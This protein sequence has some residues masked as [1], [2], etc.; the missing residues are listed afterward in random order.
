MRGIAILVAICFLA[1]GASAR[2]GEEPRDPII[3]IETGT[4]QGFVNRIVP[5]DGTKLLTI[6]DDQ[7]ARVW[8]MDGAAAGIIRGH[9][10][11]RDEGALYAA[12]I[13]PRYIAL[14]G[15]AAMPG[16][17]VFVRLLDRATLKPAGVLS[18]LPGSVTA[19]AFSADGKLLA[20]GFNGGGVRIYVLGQGAPVAQIDTRNAAVSDLSF[21]ADGSLAVSSDRVELF[22]ADARLRV[23]ATLPQG[24][25]PWRLSRSPDGQRLA[26]GSRTSAQGAILGGNGELLGV[27]VADGLGSAPAVA[28]YGGKIAIG[29][30]RADGGFLAICDQTGARM[31][32]VT[33]GEVPVTALAASARAVAF[34]DADGGWGTWPV[35]GQPVLRAR[36]DKLSFRRMRSAP[37]KVSPDG[38]RVTLSNQGADV[39]ELDLGTRQVGPVRTMPDTPGVKGSPGQDGVAGL[40][41]GERV[42]TQVA[43]SGSSDHMLGTN[44]YLRRTTRAGLT[45]WKTSSTS[46]IWGVAIAGEAGFAVAARG[47]GTLAWH[48]LADGRQAL[49]AIVF[50][51]KAWAAW[52]PEGFYD[53]GGKGAERIGYYVPRN[54][55]D[56]G[57][58]VAF[59]RTSDRFFRLDLTRAALRRGDAGNT[60]LAKARARIGVAATL[61]TANPP[62]EVRI[63]SVCGVEVNTSRA[64]ACYSAGVLGN[65][66]SAQQLVSAEQVEVTLRVDGAGTYG[67]TSVR[68]GTVAVE[69]VGERIAKT[70]GGE[71]RRFR[72]AL[73]P[74][75]ADLSFAVGT[76]DK[77]VVSA[78][79]KLRIGGVAGGRTEQG[80]LLIAA[81]G[82]SD[83]QLAMFDMKG[84]TAANDARQLSQALASSENLA[85]SAKTTAVVTDQRATR[86]GIRQALDQVVSSAQPSDI[87]VLFFSGHGDQIDG[88]YVFAPYELGSTSF[89]R[90]AADVKRGVK[91]GE[92]AMVELYRAE[93]FQQDELAR[94]LSRIRARRVIIVLDTCFGGAFDSLDA[95]QKDGLASSLSER[96]AELSGRYV[97]ASA[98]G[99]AL[100]NPDEAGAGTSVFT[101]AILDAL[102]GAADRDGDGVVSLSEIGAYVSTEVPARAHSM[103]VRQRPAISFFGD[104]YFPI[105]QRRK[106]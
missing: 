35:E 81:V 71:R 4:H 22:G 9:A 63:D 7:T 62:P 11:A 53:R 102:K 1:T 105:Y 8:D 32:M 59:D 48:D 86:D 75:D 30:N 10:G 18:N 55:R 19:L 66:I 34:G 58:Y 73:P 49:T 69:P 93:G 67:A 91:F 33:T 26:V 37:L 101:T 88:N 85:F 40:E 80:R 104:P 65:S 100:D 5:L 77:S 70:E 78:P 39:A 79:A 23:T 106:P 92:E 31:R 72:V 27:C 61:V 99:L 6:S 3:Q 68:V 41:P 54:A 90:A 46:A 44:F 47:D 82:I 64:I 24:F 43:I 14:G 38:L 74:G 13:S 56:G 57:Q 96:M 60:E 36:P 103:R 29:G 52:T 15:R 2:D 45:V 25:A 83:Y 21:G 42:L 12:A 20:A 51:D 94:Y 87:V 28:W 97:I 89:E 98:R 50:P 84:P 16:L 76:V 17:G 95:L